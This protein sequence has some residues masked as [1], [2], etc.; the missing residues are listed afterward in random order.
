MHFGRLMQSEAQKLDPIRILLG[1]M[2]E[3]LRAM[4]ED[5]LSSEADMLV[6]GQS[7][8]PDTALTSATKTKADMLITQSSDDGQDNLLDAI[9]CGSPF[10]IFAI[11]GSGHHATAIHMVREAVG[12]DAE[13]RSAFAAAI[14]ETA[15]T[16]F[17]ISS[18]REPRW[19]G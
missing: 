7:D 19:L 5:L 13:S 8:E 16:A 6:V 12:F 11:S 14:R 10:S 4:I 9:V 17:P 2:P 3:M 18:Q 1:P 15:R